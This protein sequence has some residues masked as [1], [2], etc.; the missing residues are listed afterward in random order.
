MKKNDLEEIKPILLK[1]LS[2]RKKKYA[3]N[4]IDSFDVGYDWAINDVWEA[5]VKI[6]T[7]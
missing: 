4:M 1:L 5:L 6:T 2:N 3:T 7:K